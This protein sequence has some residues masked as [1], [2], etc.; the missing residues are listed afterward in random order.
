M[1]S[2]DVTHE[3]T[4]TS[5]VLDGDKNV[6]PGDGS[7]FHLDTSTL[8][9]SATAACGTATKFASVT[10]EAPTLAASNCCVTTSDSATLYISGSPA[11]GSNQTVTRAH[12]IW[13]D[14]GNV[15]FDGGLYMG[16]SQ[17][18][19]ST[20]AIDNG[21]ANMTTGGI[22]KIDVDSG[23]TINS[24]GGGINAAGSIALG[25][26]TDAGFYV[27]CDD[28][29]TENKTSDKDLIF[30]VNDGGTFVEVT[31]IVGSVRAMR[32]A[33]ICTPA[34]PS[35]GDGGYLYAKADGKPYWRSNEIA[36]TALDS[37]GGGG[38]VPNAFFFA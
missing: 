23:S 10:L 21:T 18:V 27:K 35:G 37:A 25:A 29:Y 6:T 3:I 28:L 1:P 16:T 17:L 13:V 9:D 32:F 19:S 7:M 33:E 26:G 15:R 5:F 12:S 20:L 34:Q 31:R 36:E 24:S 22:L 38:G 8:T 11:I 30:R 14:S 4:A 2:W